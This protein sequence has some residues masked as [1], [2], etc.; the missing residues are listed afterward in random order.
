[1]SRTCGDLLFHLPRDY[2]HYSE[3][4]PVGKM[5]GGSMATIRGTVLQTRLLPRKPRRFEAMLEDG[6]GSEGGRCVLTWFNPWGLEKKIL[7]GM[8]LRVTGKVTTFQNRL[9]MVNPKHEA[10][11]WQ[12]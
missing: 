11:R 6:S 7:P 12:G 2:L 9:Q 4:A 10:S 5:Q 3:E 1:M 8:Q